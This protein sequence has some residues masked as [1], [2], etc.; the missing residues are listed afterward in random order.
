V[1]EGHE[2]ALIFV[3]DFFVVDENITATRWCY[4]LVDDF[5]NK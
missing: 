2:G 4:F 3:L 1:N 5:H